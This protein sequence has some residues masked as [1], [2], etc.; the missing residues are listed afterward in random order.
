MVISRCAVSSSVG[1][2]RMFGVGPRAF[3]SSFFVLANI[4]VFGASVDFFS[5]VYR[6]FVKG[7]F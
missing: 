3:G 5:L 1:R 4:G 7:V 6:K 2:I